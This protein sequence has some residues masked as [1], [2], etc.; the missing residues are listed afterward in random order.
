MVTLSTPLTYLLSR[1]YLPRC[2]SHPAPG[3]GSPEAYAISGGR[4]ECPVCLVHA[5]YQWVDRAT[6]WV[7]AQPVPSPLEP[8]S[9]L[10]SALDGQTS[11]CV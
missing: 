4:A 9:D 8:G 10:D 2:G 5:G 7:P 1:L 11:V 6:P 3:W